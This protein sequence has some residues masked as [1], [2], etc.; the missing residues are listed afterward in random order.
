MIIPGILEKNWNDIEG[1]LEIVYNRSLSGIDLSSQNIIYREKVTKIQIDFCDGIYVKSQTWSPLEILE[2]NK[3]QKNE[4]NSTENKKINREI[5][6]LTEKGLPHWEDFDYEA[7]LMVSPDNLKNYIEAVAQLGFGKVVLHGDE[8]DQMYEA[9]DLAVYNMLEVGISSRDI[10]LI[11]KLLNNVDYIDKIDY[12]QIMGIENIGYQHE[13]FDESVIEK[14]KIIRDILNSTPSALAGTF[15][16]EGLNTNKSR[17]RI[18]IDGAMNNET[19]QMCREAG[20]DDFVMGSAY[21]K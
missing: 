11:I 8:E 10:N 19:I 9:I 7:D 20:A 3:K 13:P 17:I 5:I 12:V 2:L 1:K 18:Q 14:I 4:N 16:R 15:P 21:F 6:N